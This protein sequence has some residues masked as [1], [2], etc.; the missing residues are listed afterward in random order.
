MPNPELSKL[1]SEYSMKNIGK[2]ISSNK[3]AN[4]D[5]FCPHNW[6]NIVSEE[7]IPHKKCTKCGEIRPMNL[8]K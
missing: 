3:I 6:I 7:N 1:V 5:I 4:D 2:C 8:D